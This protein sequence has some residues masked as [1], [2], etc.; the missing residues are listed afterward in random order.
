MIMEIILMLIAP[1]PFI[2]DVM[3][4]ESYSDLGVSVNQRLNNLLLFMSMLIR[5]LPFTRFMLSIS[6][7]KNTRSQRL[8]T[9]QG[10]EATF[11]YAVKAVMKDMPYTFLFIT[12]ILPMVIGGF[13]LRMFERPLVETSGQDFDSMGNCIWCIIITLTTVGYGD[14]FPYSHG[15]RTVAILV[16]LWGSMIVSIFVVTLTNLLEFS[17]AELKS[18]LILSKLQAKEQL[19]VD[20]VQVLNSAFK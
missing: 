13:S 8:C 17:K 10:T 16:A 3:Y 7:Y 20:A 12:L 11:M 9:M 4:R 1:Y 18:F 14:F 19:R 6:K 15:G 5:C 2:E